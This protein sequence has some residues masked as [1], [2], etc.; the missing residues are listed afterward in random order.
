MLGDGFV[1]PVAFELCR[2]RDRNGSLVCSAGCTNG[3]EVLDDTPGPTLVI[4]VDISCDP[5]SSFGILADCVPGV[6][7]DLHCCSMA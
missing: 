5:R 4:D 1:N 7:R 6:E 2:L 3:R